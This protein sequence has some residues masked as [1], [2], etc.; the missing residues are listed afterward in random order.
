MNQCREYKRYIVLVLYPMLNIVGGIGLFVY[1][2]NTQETTGDIFY[3]IIYV[4]SI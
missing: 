2:E 4:A 1:K 3:I